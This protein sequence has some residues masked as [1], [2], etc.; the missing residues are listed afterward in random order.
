VAPVS[1]ANS[2]ITISSGFPAESFFLQPANNNPQAMA[3][4]AVHFRGR[5]FKREKMFRFI[6]TPNW[7]MVPKEASPHPN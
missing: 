5:E 2:P 7:E 6:R 4:K 1:E 3:A